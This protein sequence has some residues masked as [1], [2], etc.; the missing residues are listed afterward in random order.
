VGQ[1]QT[2]QRSHLL[3]GNTAMKKSEWIIFDDS[4]FYIRGAYE[5]W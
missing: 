1:K 4:I 3:C 5:R 2:R